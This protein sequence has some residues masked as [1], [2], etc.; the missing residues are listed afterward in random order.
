[1]NWSDKTELS[2]HQSQVDQSHGFGGK[3]GVEQ[4]RQD[5]S[6]AGWNEKVELAKHESQKGKYVLFTEYND[7]SDYATGFGGKYGVQR[8]KLLIISYPDSTQIF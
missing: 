5:K 8:G 3:Y 2:K 7:V 4:D 6:A 1:L